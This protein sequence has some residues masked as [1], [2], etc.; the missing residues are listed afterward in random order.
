MDQVDDILIHFGIPGMK[1]GHRKRQ[2]STYPTGGRGPGSRMLTKGRQ[3]KKDE[4]NLDLLER[5][6]HLSVGIT[7]KRQAHFDERDKTLLKK[8]IS[9]LKEEIEKKKVEPSEDAKRIY[10]IKKKKLVEMSNAELKA[11]NERLQLERQYKEL[12]KQ[13]L[14][15]GQKFVRDLIVDSAKQTARNYTAQLMGK[16]TDKL[17]KKLLDM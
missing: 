3:L 15:P 2:S 7:K 4:Q 5:G 11:V 10:K 17:I 12:S 6:K 16:G 9:K 1:W 8:N 14:S 13:D